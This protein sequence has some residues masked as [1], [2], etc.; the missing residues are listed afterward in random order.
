MFYFG[1]INNSIHKMFQYN[2]LLMKQIKREKNDTILKDS[3]VGI[4]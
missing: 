1:E 2:L 4:W 3:L